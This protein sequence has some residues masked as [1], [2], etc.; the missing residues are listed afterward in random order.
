MALS[1]IKVIRFLY[2]FFAR[3]F[4]ACN[5]NLPPT[6]FYLRSQ[7]V[8]GHF[9]IYQLG[10]I[11]SFRSLPYRNQSIDLQRKSV[12]WFLYNRDL[13]HERVNMN[14][15]YKVHLAI[16]FPFLLWCKLFHLRLMYIPAHSI[17]DHSFSTYAKFSEKL[18][19]LTP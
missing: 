19:S 1:F 2:P 15:E 12:D 8:H 4:S 6:T 3:H 7:K 18:T 14:Y 16:L 9:S 5:S 17:S 10:P 11:S 13:R